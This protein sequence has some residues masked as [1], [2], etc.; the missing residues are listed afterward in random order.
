MSGIF[1]DEAT[2][3]SRF[4]EI[5]RDS[6][7]HASVTTI[8]GTKFITDGDVQSQGFC[9]VIIEFKN[10]IGSK[11]AEP[12]AQAISY[13]IHATKSSVTRMSSFRFPRILITL[14]GK[15]AILHR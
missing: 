3:A 6:G 14:F 8:E 4:P 12:H 7:I 11:G 1:K 2:R 15:L 10:E 13:Y 5:L 9:R